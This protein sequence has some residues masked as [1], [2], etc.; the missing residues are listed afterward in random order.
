MTKNSKT[1]QKHNKSEEKHESICFYYV[2][3]PFC[4]FIVFIMLCYENLAFV[5][6]YLFLL[7]LLFFNK[8]V[9]LLV[10]CYVVH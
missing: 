9:C 8:N 2:A 4:Y 7:F 3:L 10:F 1:Y 5:I 6:S